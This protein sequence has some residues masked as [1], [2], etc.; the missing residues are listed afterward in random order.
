MT[1]EQENLAALLSELENEKRL[2]GAGAEREAH[3]RSL[4]HQECVVVRTFD[5]PPALT[6][7]AT[8]CACGGEW[9]YVARPV[10][11]GQDLGTGGALM[12][13]L[14]CV[15]HTEVRVVPAPTGK[16]TVWDVLVRKARPQ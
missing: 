10:T 6:I 11:L 2:S 9:A 13:M 8:S 7:E 3:L 1:V 16:Q 15:C 12:V 5:R 14:G 4:L